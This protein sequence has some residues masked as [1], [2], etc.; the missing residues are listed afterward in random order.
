[1]FQVF[2]LGGGGGGGKRGSGS[3]K[4]SIAIPWAASRNSQ[5]EGGYIL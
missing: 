2:F 1:M 5:G 4:K 3:R